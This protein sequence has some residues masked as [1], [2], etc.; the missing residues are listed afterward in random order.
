MGYVGQITVTICYKQNVFHIG[1]HSQGS[2]MGELGSWGREK[3][4]RGSVSQV[5]GRGQGEVACLRRL[6]KGAGPAE[7]LSISHAYLT[8]TMDVIQNV[9][10]R[11]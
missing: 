11:Y 10:V 3:V 6:R 8:K 2:Q 4:G 7:L 9:Y 5:I 1:C